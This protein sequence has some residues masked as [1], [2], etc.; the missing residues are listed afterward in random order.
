[1]L[2]Q[3]FRIDQ[4][5]T[6]PSDEVGLAVLGYPIAHSISPQLHG[7]ALQAM[8][9]RETEFKRWN[10]RKIEVPPG[11]LPLALPQLAQLGFRGL[12]LT[13]PHKVDVLPLLGS[14]DDRARAM[15]AV[16]TLSWEKNG[17]KGYN[18]DGVGLSWAIKQAFK[19]PVNEFLVLVLGAGGAARAAVA[20]CLFEG[21]TNLSLFN[22]S[23]DR[24]KQLCQALKEN[25]MEQEIS[26]LE[27]FCLPYQNS[28]R[29]V[30]VINATSLGL[31]MEDPAPIDLDCLN[32]DVCVYDMVYNPPVTRLL[33]QAKR[34][35]F[36][37]ANGLGMLVGQ[38]AR[39]L[40]IWTAKSVPMEAMSR[41]A[42]R[43]MSGR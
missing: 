19:C 28:Q 9:E 5:K 39:S 12:N 6:L 7:A 10:Y 11:E 33:S 35:G 14:I 27:S 17:W 1:M 16:N 21:C 32:G 8:A 25:G 2:E 30:L 29:P 40:E 22:R 37:W 38:A 13:I 18:T 23:I 24:A 41:A 4:L 36:A 15:G 34:K 31:R 42:A 43:A 20:Q 3:T 26:V